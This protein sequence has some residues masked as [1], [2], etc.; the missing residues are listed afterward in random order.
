MH[1]RSP[2]ARAIKIN[3]APTITNPM[4]PRHMFASGRETFSSD[5]GRHGCH[6]VQVHDPENEQDGGQVGTTEAAV[7]S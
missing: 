1:H 4:A 2:A 5:S 7:K 6:C 3:P